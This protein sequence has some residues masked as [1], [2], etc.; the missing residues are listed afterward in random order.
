MV[1]TRN[2]A[3]RRFSRALVPRPSIRIL[4]LA[5]ALTPH[6]ACKKKATEEQSLAPAVLAADAGATPAAAT[7]AGDAVATT[8][9]RAPA[10]EEAAAAKLRACVERGE[11]CDTISGAERGLALR[12]LCRQERG[13]RCDSLSAEQMAQ[14]LA[15][16]IDGPSGQISH[17]EVWDAL[18]K[19][20]GVPECDAPLVAENDRLRPPVS[21]SREQLGGA[22]RIEVQSDA[23]YCNQQRVALLKDENGIRTVDELAKAG[24]RSSY[25]IEDLKLQ[26][27]GYRTQLDEIA[28]R[29]GR[30]F[31]TARSALVVAD[32][33]TPV[34]ILKEILYT[35]REAGYDRF[36]LAV[37]RA[38]A[39][40][41]HSAARA[42]G[43]FA[44]I[45]FFRGDERR[46]AGGGAAEELVDLRLVL[47]LTEGSMTLM[48]ARDV[49]AAVMPEDPATGTKGRIDIPHVALSAADVERD[50]LAACP[51]PPDA[52]FDDC[53]YW[54]YMAEVLSSCFGGPAAQVKVPDLR[55][56]N[57]ALR[58]IAERADAAYP[59]DLADRWQLNIKAEDDI[60]LCPLVGILDAAR[61][62]NP[63]FDWTA[64]PAFQARYDQL[65]AQDVLDPLLDPSSFAPDLR[66]SLLFPVIGFVN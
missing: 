7:A 9:V 53:A 17:E 47:I 14:T 57:L 6:A 50:R 38:A 55:T 33:A 22:A 45:T 58:G 51:S 8:T 28:R 37:R 43:D 15:Q 30:H 66:S 11:G 1:P 26:L 10:D 32:A 5:L 54:T 63:T 27:E 18:F 21:L 52:D 40:Q 29:T 39:A 60:P 13:T 25:I 41:D 31:L 42:C 12:F 16:P 20:W 36:Q 23:I 34:R 61:F 35:S 3:N 2:P 59:D 64:D 65:L 62:R 19:L 46:A 48:T 56:L 24:G 4:A 44:A 49:S